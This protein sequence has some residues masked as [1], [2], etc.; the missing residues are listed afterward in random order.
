MR[1]S[2]SVLGSLFH[3]KHTLLNMS[4]DPDRV[5]HIIVEEGTFALTVAQLRF[6]SPNV[7]T[8]RLDREPNVPAFWFDEHDREFDSGDFSFIDAYLMGKWRRLRPAS[9]RLLVRPEH[10]LGI[11]WADFSTP[12]G[13]DIV[14][15]ASTRPP[16]TRAFAP[17]GPLIV[18]P[19][20]WHLVMNDAIIF[21]LKR[22]QELLEALKQS[23]EPPIPAYPLDKGKSAFLTGPTSFR[24]AVQLRS[25]D[26][27]PLGEIIKLENGPFPMFQFSDVILSCVLCMFWSGSERF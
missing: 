24:R 12:P 20:V 2:T 26:S 9:P 17:Q 10:D 18:T 16:A 27:K 13:H 8:R 5:V 11:Q 15:G 22:L 7:F 19:E 25:V 4:G 6:D 14:G 23:W 1:T 3:L 21:Q